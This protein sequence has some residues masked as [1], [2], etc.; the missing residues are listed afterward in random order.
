M[1]VAARSPL[2]AGMSGARLRR[3]LGAPGAGRARLPQAASGGS[4]L[5]YAEPHPM[6]L[7]PVAWTLCGF[8]SSGG[9]GGQRGLPAAGPRARAHQ[10]EER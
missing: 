4:H 9:A 1:E 3:N 6:I 10:A 7:E 8:V 2:Q 5:L